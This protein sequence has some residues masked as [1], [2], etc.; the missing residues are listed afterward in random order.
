MDAIMVD[1]GI[2]S[3]ME[4]DSGDFMTIEFALDCYIINMVVVDFTEDTSQVTHYAILATIVNGIV[5]NNM[6]ADLFPAPAITSG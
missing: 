3:R 4:L 5:A 2:N 6:R 1:V